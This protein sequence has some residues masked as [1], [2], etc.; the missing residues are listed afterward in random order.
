[1]NRYDEAVRRLADGFSE[2]FAE[3]C[4]GHEKMHEMMMDLASE[5]VEENIPVVSE[6]S[7]IDLAAELIMSITVTKV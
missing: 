2:E 6:D 5:F 4:A 1:M 3:W 7:Q